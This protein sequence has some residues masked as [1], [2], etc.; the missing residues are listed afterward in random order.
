MAFVSG[1]A[2]FVRWQVWLDRVWL[3]GMFGWIQIWLNGV[4]SWITWLVGWYTWL[5]DTVGW[6][7]W[8]VRRHSLLDEMV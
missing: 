5:D 2:W 7:G 8:L 1:M 4:I 6:M 3:D